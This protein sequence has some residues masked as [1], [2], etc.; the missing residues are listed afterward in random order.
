LISLDDEQKA[1]LE[2]LGTDQT[3]LLRSLGLKPV[4]GSCSLPLEI[5]ELQNACLVL[6]AVSVESCGGLVKPISFNHFSNQ[7]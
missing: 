2:P 1:S 3:I 7:G 5:T 4:W 6:K